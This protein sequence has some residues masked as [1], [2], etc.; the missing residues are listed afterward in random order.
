MPTHESALREIE[1]RR[2]TI[3]TNE[4]DSGAREGK[5]DAARTATQLQY[6]AAGVQ[7]KVPPERYVAPPQRLRI[8]PV[9]ERRVIVPAFMAFHHTFCP[10]VANSIVCWISTN[11]AVAEASVS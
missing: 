3:D 11:A 2:G 8:F 5:R 7:G 1:H 6:L 10:T 9:V 4:L